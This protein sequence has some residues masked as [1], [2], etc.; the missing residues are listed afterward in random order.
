MAQRD[1]VEVGR[2]RVFREE[3]VLLL[4]EAK[5]SG[6]DAAAHAD[7][8]G[9]DGGQGRVEAFAGAKLIEP[10]RERLEQSAILVAE[11]GIALPRVLAEVAAGGRVRHEQ[12]LDLAAAGAVWQTE[13]VGPRGQVQS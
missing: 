2:Q 8:S 11:A 4:A 10:R 13:E 1:V 9:Q 6:Q 5:K 3:H 12:E 7:V